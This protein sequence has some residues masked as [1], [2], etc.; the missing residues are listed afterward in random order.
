MGDV[1]R[2]EHE[3]GALRWQIE[4]SGTSRT[5]AY[6]ASSSLAVDQAVQN[7]RNLLSD[8][9]VKA[10]ISSSF[11]IGKEYVVGACDGRQ[12]SAKLYSPAEQTTIAPLS[13]V[14]IRGLLSPTERGHRLNMWIQPG[15]GGLITTVVG[16]VLGLGALLFGILRFATHSEWKSLAICCAIAAVLMAAATGLLIWS[17]HEGRQNEDEVLDRLAECGGYDF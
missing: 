7:L 13:R 6:E 5:R 15:P 8:R 4:G 17:S 1:K 9:A 11:G 12:F 3:Y 14:L 10:S 2:L 16:W